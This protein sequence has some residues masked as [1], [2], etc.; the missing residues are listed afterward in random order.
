MKEVLL[1]IVLAV[2]AVFGYFVM[3]HLDKFLENNRKLRR[4]DEKDD[5]D[6]GK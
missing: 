5:K 1:I 4:R 6:K 3:K 2:Y